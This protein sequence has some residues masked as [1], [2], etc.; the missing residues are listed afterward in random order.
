MLGG[1]PPER[2]VLSTAWWGI[3]VC[4]LPKEAVHQ[5]CRRLEKLEPPGRCGQLHTLPAGD[6]CPGV[7][8]VA[9]PAGGPAARYM[10]VMLSS[11]P[12]L[13]IHVVIVAIIR[14]VWAT[15]VV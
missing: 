11:G 2:S 3:G 10:L 4:D 6:V 15:L 8:A 5:L 14:A 13:F 12:L 7:A 9:V 1:W